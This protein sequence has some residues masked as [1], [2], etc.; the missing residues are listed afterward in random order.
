MICSDRTRGSVERAVDCE[1]SKP[2]LGSPGPYDPLPK[3][4]RKDCLKECPAQANPKHLAGGPEK[5][6]DTRGDGYI[7]PGHVRNQ[8]LRSH[9]E[10]EN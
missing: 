10:Q 4:F 8:C 1:E 9:L 7:L 5:I 3:L 6:A 2:D